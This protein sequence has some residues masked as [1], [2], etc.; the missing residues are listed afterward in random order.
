MHPVG[1]PQ[2]PRPRR[3]VV[4]GVLLA[5]AMLTLAPTATGRT[6]G[7]EIESVTACIDRNAGSASWA[8]TC[9][10]VAETRLDEDLNN[11]YRNLLDATPPSLKDGVIG[12]ERA[13]LGYRDAEC[14]TRRDN[15]PKGQDWAIAIGRCTIDLTGERI[16]RLRASTP[17]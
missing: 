2:A 14:A 13:W 16:R 8:R 1:R 7:P 6:G 5:T 17:R 12:A 10:A 9:V 4:I 15:R 11:A 3:G